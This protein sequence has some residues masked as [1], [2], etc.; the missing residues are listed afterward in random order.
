MIKNLLNNNTLNPN[1][2]SGFID[3]EGCFHVSIIR[4][5]SL[6]LGVSVRAIFQI[7]LHKKDKLLLEKIQD[8]FGVGRVSMRSDNA[9]V[10]EV[11]SIKDVQIILNH[12]EAYPLITDKWADLQMFKQVVELMINQ[13]HLTTE[14]LAKIV[15]IKA[16]MNFGTMP[17]A[18]VALY[19]AIVPVKR[20]ER[21]EF[22]IYHPYWVT[23]YVEGEG[24][25]FVNIY[26]RKDTVLGEGVK[27]VFKITQDK[28]NLALLESFTDIFTAGKVYK[29]S[30]T[31]KVLDFM[32]TGLADITKYVIPFFETHPLQGAKKDD[33][34]DFV[35]VGELM[36]SK[37]HLNK[38]GLNQIY[39]IKSGMNSQR[40]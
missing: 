17:E 12:L 5:S 8:F 36:R 14:G 2:V 37:S 33:Y 6:K 25:F 18:I 38:D 22:T 30:P 31:V 32:I 28:K 24:M 16:S 7:S 21:T 23:G 15:N 4:N 34:N 39:I 35:K 29:Q 3:A 19:P 26:K 20:P 11:A 27:L 1:Y 13:E 10:Y 9:V 40:Y